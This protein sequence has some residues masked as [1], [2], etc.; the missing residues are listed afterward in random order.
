MIFHLMPH[1]TPH[2]LTTASH[3]HE[4]TRREETIVHLDYMMS[5]VGSN[6]CGPELLPQYRL[7]QS[8]IDFKLRLRPIF[9]EEESLPD[10]VKSEIVE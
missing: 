7:S 9:T 6:S 5:G 2:D 8:E 1:F 4:L 10:I 3:P